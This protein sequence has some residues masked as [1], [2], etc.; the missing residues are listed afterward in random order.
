VK[1]IV[2]LLFLGSLLQAQI[3]EGYY[4][5]T[6]NLT[7]GE[8]KSALH[9]IIKD[10]IQFSYSQT[11]DI[12]K[13][14][15]RD[16]DNP[17]NVILIYTGW[18]V[19]A[20][21]EYNN[22]N[23]WNREH[24]WAVSHGDFGTS[25]GAGTDV[26]HV[27]ASDISVNSAR[28]N[29]DF[30]NGGIE[31]I[32]PDGPTGCYTTTYTWEPRPEDKGDVARMMFYM[33]VRYEGGFG[34]PDLE[35][36]DYAPSSPNNEPYH[37][38][39]STLYQWHT[40]DP[41]DDR[42]LYRNDVIYYQYQQNRN[43]FIDYPEFAGLIWFPNSSDDDSS[44]DFPETQLLQNSPNPFNPSTTIAFSINWGETGVLTIYNPK[45]EKLLQKQF[46]EGSH[47]YHW[48][49]ARFSSGIY[50]YALESSSGAKKTRKMLLLK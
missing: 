6:E 36:V 43:P 1:Y 37:G 15:D 14:T 34:E 39:L 11:W 7:G 2:V 32:D 18:S 16:P 13:V 50:I 27:R 31:Y 33:A 10:H 45:G 20:A 5:G 12:L 38:V 49:A 46:G 21:Q 44:I 35:L 47:S 40:E 9:H 42:E 3:P 48:N 41:V 4:N 26:H 17:A 23:G 19:D 30:D 22:G 28:G 8:L 29:K 25:M 24:V